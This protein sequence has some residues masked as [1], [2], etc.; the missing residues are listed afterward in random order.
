M[1]P[2]SFFAVFIPV[3]SIILTTLFIILTGNKKPDPR[4]V[5]VGI[6]ILAA[7]FLTALI[8]FMGITS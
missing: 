4:M 2:S 6:I 1:K 3:F 5:K 7:G 8:V